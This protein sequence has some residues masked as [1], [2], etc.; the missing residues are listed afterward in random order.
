MLNTTYRLQKAAVSY[1]K[2]LSRKNV[3]RRSPSYKDRCPD[4]TF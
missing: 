1:C 3:G 2:P 4:I